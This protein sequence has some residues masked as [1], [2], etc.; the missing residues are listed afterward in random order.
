MDMK[1][2]EALSY[3]DPDNYGDWIAVGMALKHE[4]FGVDEWDRWSQGS[5]KYKPGMCEKKWKSFQELNGS[6]PVTGGTII[7][8]ARER[9]WSGSGER[10]AVAFG[11][12]DEVE[13]IGRDYKIVDTGFVREE[14]V[15]E[16]D[17]KYDGAADLREYLSTLFKPDEYVGYCDELTD[18]GGGRWVPKRGKMRRT[19]GEL[20]EDLRNGFKKS[21][22]KSDSPGGGMIRFNPLDGNGESDINVTRYTYCLIESDKD[23]IE[24]QY[25]LYKAMNLPIAVLV[26]SGNKS[27]HAIVH[28]DAESLHQ[29]RERVNF[30]Y[31]FCKKNG[32]KVDEQDK[33]ASRYSRM[34]GVMRDGKQQYIVTTNIGAGNYADWRQ[35]VD[36]QNDNLPKD[37]SL[38]EIWD[39]LPPLKPELISG[40][41]RV[42]HKLLLSGPSKAGKSFLLMY[43]A[44]AIAEGLDWIGHHCTQGKVLYINLE[45]DEASCYH[46]FVEIYRALGIEPKNL[47]NITI[48]NLRGRAVPMDKLTPFLIHRF[49][50]KGYA[51]VIIDPIYKVITGDENS[52]TEMSQFCSYFDRAAIDINAAMIYCHHHSKG[53]GMKY[54]KAADRASGSGVFAR[55]PDAILDLLELEATTDMIERY[56]KQIPGDNGVTAWELSGTL[57]EFP[58]IAPVRLW[59]D[60][61]AHRVD[62]WNF[63]ADAKEGETAARKSGI[64][65]KQKSAV[66]WDKDLAAAYEANGGDDKHPVAFDAIVA[67]MQGGGSQKPVTIERNLRKRR[68]TVQDLGGT[69][70]VLRSCP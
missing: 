40:I 43:L 58:P 16:P 13:E 36:E 62:Q 52:A 15:P 41:L 34:P 66:D 53:A 42:G 57:R 12:D 47:G 10:K 70:M 7:Q 3:I 31:E 51:A 54:A 61:P 5:T 29:Y 49:K 26:H 1:I 11:W 4:G 30:I 6:A 64:G 59:F 20:I 56:R 38:A 63:L 33:N 19:A 69:K 14:S 48:W 21:T 25:S 8:M 37:V 35:W 17:K 39:N 65:K 60:Y 46:R 28:V 2:L 32:L 55:D 23:S 50:D 9:G 24:K 68:Y 45:L 67:Y 44:I 18:D 22:I 27:L